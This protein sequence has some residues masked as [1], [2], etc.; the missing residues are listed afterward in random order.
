MAERKMRSE[1][2]SLSAQ[3]RWGKAK[4]KDKQNQGPGDAGAS[5]KQCSEDANQNQNQS[6]AVEAKASTGA[7]APADPAAIVFGQGLELLK[8]GGVRE[9]N[10]RSMLGKWRRDYGDASLIAALG[11]AQRAGALDPVAFIEKALRASSQIVRGAPK[12]ATVGGIKGEWTAMG[13]IP[14]G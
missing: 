7:K 11:N 1:K 9:G 14:E 6:S 5:S 3:E 8:A 12:L 2:A 10:A 4:A 13:F